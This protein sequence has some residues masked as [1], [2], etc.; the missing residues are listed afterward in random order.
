MATTV[1]TVA[2]ILYVAVSTTVVVL[3]DV[4][5]VRYYDGYF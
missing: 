5:L 4:V 3:V 1:V 2:V